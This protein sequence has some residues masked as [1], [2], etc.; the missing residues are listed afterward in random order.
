MTNIDNVVVH[1]E[2]KGTK[3][4]SSDHL[5]LLGGSESNKNDMPKGKHD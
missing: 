3:Q 4:S 5:L 2:M 1:L